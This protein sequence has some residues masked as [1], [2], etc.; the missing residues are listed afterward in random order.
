[1]KKADHSTFWERFLLCLIQACKIDSNPPPFSRRAANPPSK[2]V[3]ARTLR[4]QLLER[5]GSKISFI[6]KLDA[7]RGLPLAIKIT[8]D[9]API[10]RPRNA[11][12]KSTTEIRATK[13][14][15]I[16]KMGIL[17]WEKIKVI[18]NNNRTNIFPKFMWIWRLWK[19][20]FLTN[21]KLMSWVFCPKYY[22]GAYLFCFFAG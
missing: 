4:F 5:A 2:R 8:P 21:R 10:N 1:M 18:A 19:W 11:F 13:L 17:N 12:L 15:Q 3:N 14:G 20:K 9:I 22:R 7:T 6:S 16:E